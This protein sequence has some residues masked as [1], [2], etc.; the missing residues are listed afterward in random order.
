MM[1]AVRL[2]GFGTGGWA[3]ALLSA[4]AVTFLLSIAGFAL[5]AVFGGIAAAARVGG[6]RALAF[7]ADAYGTVFRGIPDLLTIYLLYFGGSMTLTTVAHL[8][9]ADGFFG[10]PAFATGT[11]AIGIISGAYQAEVYRGAYLAVDRSQA[12][13][14]YAHGLSK[15]L[16]LRLVILPQLM[17]YA[18]P[19]LGNVW[20]LVLKDSAL[21][22]VI[23]LVELMRQ[24]QIG[25]GSTR[26][27]FVFYVAAAALYFAIAA[28]TGV[29]F[30]RAERIAMRGVGRS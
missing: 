18:I 13:A 25:A 12:E 24:A 14:A 23:G 10:L 20:Q 9:G 8:F 1:E 7:I 3:A 21:I 28:A 11:L 29:L 22:S 5:G 30:R 26:Q 16:T 6:S 19:G 2:L 4:S 15:Y 27:P 17:R